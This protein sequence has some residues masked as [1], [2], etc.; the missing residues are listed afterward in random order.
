MD[1]TVHM[2]TFSNPFYTSLFSWHVYLPMQIANTCCRTVFPNA[3]MVEA[4]LQYLESVNFSWHCHGM[5]HALFAA[6]FLKD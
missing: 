5:P 3:T 1:L 6:L 2:P 4:K